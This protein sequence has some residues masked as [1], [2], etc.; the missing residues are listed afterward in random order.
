MYVVQDYSVASIRDGEG[1]EEVYG[2]HQQENIRICIR[3][4]TK[5]LYF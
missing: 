1:G 5:K 3:E 4:A 2:S